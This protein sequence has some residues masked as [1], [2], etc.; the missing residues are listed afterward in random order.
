LTLHDTK[1]EKQLAEWLAS[2][3]A[4][5]LL[6]CEQKLLHEELARLT[7]FRLLQVGAW[8]FDADLL[9]QA[10]TL[11][12][13]RLT[14]WPQRPDDIV[15]DGYNL[16]IASGSVDAVLLAH[17]LDL[18]DQPHRLLRECER[19]L[20]DRGRLVVL[21]F[22]PL[23]LWALA[24]RV[25]GRGHGRFVR[26]ARF[27]PAGRVCDWLR[28]LGFEQK[29]IVRYGVG[30][31]FFGHAQD[32]CSGSRQ[33]QLLAWLA[34]AWLIVARKRVMPLTCVRLSSPQ[35][36]RSASGH[37]GLANHGAGRVDSRRQIT[38]FRR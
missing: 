23:S 15:F 9:G 31:P 18:A 7:G 13:W 27:Y 25:P 19:I 3:R 32:V 4:Q 35:P 17:A 14:R 2:P 34:Q 22:N 20:S 1:R 26:P 10:G 33:V 30:F 21:G 5:L 24:Q 38:C 16:P 28:L 29:R 37:V 12:Q 11:C 8:G 6:E 36:S